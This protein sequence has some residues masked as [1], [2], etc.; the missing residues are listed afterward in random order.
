MLKTFWGGESGWRDEQLDDGTVI[1]TAPDG[2]EHLTTPG[3][4]LLFPELSA[5][6]TTVTTT[7]RPAP[8]TTG[9]TMPR[10]R[11]TRT[12]D[13]AARIAAERELNGSTSRPA[14]GLTVAD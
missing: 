9:L 8:H 12:E 1:W 14:A 4:R 3:S 5:P 7:G 2:R 13:H 11:T 6:T 10:R